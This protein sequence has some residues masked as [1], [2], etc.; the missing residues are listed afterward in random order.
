[1]TFVIYGKVNNKLTLFIKCLSVEQMLPGVVRSAVFVN[2][3][4]AT[5]FFSPYH[6]TGLKSVSSITAYIRPVL[7]SYA[8]PRADRFDSNIFASKYI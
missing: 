6:A 7:C 4:H 1:M 5:L 8:R 2:N 3:G